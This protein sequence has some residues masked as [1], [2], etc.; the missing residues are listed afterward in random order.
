MNFLRTL[1]ELEIRI[2]RSTDAKSWDV[3]TTTTLFNLI[4][5]V[6]KAEYTKSKHYKFI[7]KNFRLTYKDLAEKWS[8]MFSYDGEVK[9]EEAFRSQTSTLSR[10]LQ[11]MFPEDLTEIFLTQDFNRL[12]YIQDV[13]DIISGY[14]MTCEEY[15]IDEVIMEAGKKFEHEYDISQLTT[16]IEAI[17]PYLKRNI[18]D[19]LD[20][21]DKDKLSYII[22]KLKEPYI[23][24]KTRKID[25]AKLDIINGLSGKTTQGGESKSY[26]ID[27]LNEFAKNDNGYP[28][29]N[30][31]IQQINRLLHMQ[32]YEGLKDYIDRRKINN[33]DIQE[34]LR[35]FEAGVSL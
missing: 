33:M 31:N 6:T 35:L 2:L 32:D 19:A 28:Q 10:Q 15:F 14:P 25:K 7:A 8:D 34:A 22:F 4:E 30:I 27:M 1:R 24:S 13:I 12:R 26:F 5:F 23:V 17:R 29:N 11:A 3:Q 21:I 18:Y 20:G 9:S 16:E